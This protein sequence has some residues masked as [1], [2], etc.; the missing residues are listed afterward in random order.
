MCQPKGKPAAIPPDCVCHRGASVRRRD[1]G[2]GTAIGV[3][4]QQ[5]RSVGFVRGRC[6]CG[7]EYLRRRSVSVLFEPIYSVIECVGQDRADQTL[8]L[9]VS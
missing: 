8:L 9:R 7:G 5:L 3:T 2:T 1:G 4:D 6:G